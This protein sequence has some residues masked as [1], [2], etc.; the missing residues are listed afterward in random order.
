MFINVVGESDWLII[1]GFRVFLC[2]MQRKQDLMLIQ[3]ERCHL[4]AQP[5]MHLPRDDGVRGNSKRPGDCASQTI[6]G[7]CV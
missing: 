1:R 3:V 6:F 2:A 4:Q 7:V 5:A